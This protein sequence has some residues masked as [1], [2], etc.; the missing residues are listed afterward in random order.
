[1]DR[2]SKMSSE[3]RAFR[4]YLRTG[5]RLSDEHFGDETEVQ[6]KFNPYHDP[7]NG[8]FTFAPGGPRS[9]RRVITSRSKPSTPARLSTAPLRKPAADRPTSA[10][11]RSVTEQAANTSLTRTHNEFLSYGRRIPAKPGTQD[12][13]SYRGRGGMSKATFKDQF[14]S[15]HGNAIRA[16][17]RK[18]DLPAPLVA[19]VAYAE[20]GSDDWKNDTAYAVRSESGRS[21]PE[22]LGVVEGGRKLVQNLNRPRDETSFGP[23]NIQ[24]RRAAEILGYGNDINKMSETARR[25]LVPTTRDPVAATFMLAKHLSDLRNIDFAGTPGKAL[26]A[27]QMLTIATRYN[28]GPEA[29]VD[30]IRKD[31]RAGRNYLRNWKHVS[32]LLTN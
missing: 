10:P 8:Q 6:L 24:Q 2:D 1:M 28:V 32:G 21:I 3:H 14:I 4:H 15:G 9:A 7:S 19:S 30:E 23:Y 16:A 13:W 26:T 29:T 18:Y 25:A 20:L 11:H 5:Q 17:A 22:G 31:T 12:T 27:N